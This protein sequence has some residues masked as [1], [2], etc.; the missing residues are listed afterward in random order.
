MA[1]T[2][3][4]VT[5]LTRLEKNEMEKQRTLVLK[6]GSTS[7]T[8]GLKQMGKNLKGK[9]VIG[10]EGFKNIWNLGWKNG[11]SSEFV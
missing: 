7:K 4:I 5:I 1:L 2:Y 6:R 9:R 8:K 10:V 3:T 11:I